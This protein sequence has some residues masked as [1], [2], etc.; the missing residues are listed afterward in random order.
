MASF[1]KKMMP[2]ETHAMWVWILL[3]MVAYL[4][5]PWYAQYSLEDWL[6]SYST[7]YR[8]GDA[9]N[10]ILQAL[11]MQRPW[12]ML[13]FLGLLL[14]ATATFV[15]DAK[16]RGQI[17]LAGALLG[18]VG[19]LGSGFLIGPQG[20]Y[21]ENLAVMFP[22]LPTGQ[23]ALGWGGGVVLF[24]LVIL[25]GFGLAGLGY[26]R[27][28]RFVA[29]TVI[30]CSVLLALFIA[31]PVGKTIAG[32]FMNEAGQ[33]APG[34]LLDR[35]F[36]ERVWGLGCLRGG[37]QCG[38]AWNTI[39][40][41][42]LTATSTTIL[43]L[44][45]ALIAERG[46]GSKSPAVEKILRL[47]A[48]LPIITPPFI[49]GLGLILLFGRAGIVNQVLEYLFAIEPSRW[50]YGVQGVWLAQTF[51]FTPIA[52]LIIRGVL[53]GLSPSLEEAAQTLRASSVRTFF[54]VTL[55]LLTPALANAFLVGFIESLAD[56]GNPIILG[57]QYAVL[58]T[59]I[60]FAIVG[61]QLDPG[62]AAALGL[63]L[64]VMALAVFFLQ[65]MVVGKASY[66]TVSGK[67]DSGIPLALPPLL[68]RFIYPIGFGWV[69]FT[70]VL[71]IFAIMGGLVETWGRDFTPTLKHY[72][73]MFE[74]QWGEFGIVWAGGAWNSFWTTIKLALIAAPITAAIG[75]LMA[76]IIARTQFK[77]LAAFEFVALLA[78][79]IPGTVIG[80]S[81]IMAFNIPPIELVGTAAI[82]VLCFLFRNLPVGVRAGVAAFKQLDKSLDE[83]S[84]ML[85]A[86]SFTTLRKII[87]PLLRP[88]VVAALIYSFVRAVT[89]VSA[90]IF[91]VN[92]QT[93]LATV[94]IIGRVGNSDYGGAL[95]YC[96]MMVLL[97]LVAVGMIQLLVGER[98]LGRRVAKN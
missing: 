90:V 5:L 7:V 48:L 14:C 58:S 66:T 95:A 28:D 69:A 43:G 34:S 88:A 74:I 84:T 64:T 15:D 93:E 79:A 23:Q 30:G 55:P 62:K 70:I 57:G 87:F 19:I 81:Y 27:S 56:F 96:T 32:A 29:A 86:S 38:V 17:T 9:A 54:T 21:F 68:K 63:L 37:Y 35:L 52:F 82:V 25:I 78:F 13:G 8:T 33:F 2:Q 22:A 49:V 4:L 91:L 94:Y 39:F 46:L 60:F 85:H 26:F 98:R 20:W 67:G 50:F 11:F 61:A 75:M 65:R 10:G 6:G 92:A 72:I 97:M 16:R 89:T 51:A 59:E 1:L 76:Y 31:F 45:L 3:G 47:L 80:V 42:L 41:G 12:V 40:L 18:F 53:Q 83:A 77:G 36:T 44:I 73:R 24:S 71:Y